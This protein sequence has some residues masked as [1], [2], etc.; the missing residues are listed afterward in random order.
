MECKNVVNALPAYLDLALN[1]GEESDIKG[2]LA[3][4]PDCRN[5]ALL[6]SSSWNALGVLES[7]QPSEDFRARFWA[8]AR[9]EEKAREAQ[10]GIFARFPLA[11]V[12]AGFLV[13]W[14]LGVAGG[15]RFFESRRT[16]STPLDET[17]NRF[18][19]PY[20]NDSIEKIFLEGRTPSDYHGGNV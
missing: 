8:R 15:V 7:I 18:V 11:P 6:L 4:C 9:R 19:S 3:Q 2:H 1:K 13:L 12:L 20:P 17:L 14:M 10:T 16:S 5:E